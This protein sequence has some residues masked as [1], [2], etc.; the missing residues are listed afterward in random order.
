MF[1][2]EAIEKLS[3]PSQLDQLVKVVSLPY[4]VWVLG[5]AVIIGSAGAW[6]VLGSVS[7][8]VSGTALLHIRTGRVFPVAAAQQGL[9]DKLE[10]SAGDAVRKG[11][12]IARVRSLELRDQLQAAKA[13]L[14]A[15]QSRLKDIQEAHKRERAA[16]LKVRKQQYDALNTKIANAEKQR[17][18]IEGHL[19]ELNKLS[20]RGET[21][22]SSVDQMQDSLYKAIQDRGDAQASKANVEATF[23]SG[24]S[25]RAQERR[26]AKFEILKQQLTIGRLETDL[27]EAE[28]LLAPVDGSIT[29]VLVAEG[30]RITP[31]TVIMRV[32]E[33][34]DK[35]TALGFFRNKDGKRLE[36]GM[37]VNVSPSDVEAEE[38]GTIVGK[39]VRVAPRPQSQQALEALLQ[40]SS[41][42][43]H[44]TASGAPILVVIQ[45]AADASAPSGYKWSSGKGPPFKITD[46]TMGSARVIVEEQAPISLLVPFL[47]KLIGDTGG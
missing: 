23:L 5:L 25:E 4:W 38:Y 32:S 2:K 24:E 46:G 28:T 47:K 45:L 26:N 20:R 36:P 11:Q 1:R 22:R 27:K 35:L 39:L 16:A 33:R 19:E 44:L 10:V 14:T 41:V 7:T 30:A 8:R 42:A 18:R 43:Q 34:T 3:A 21:L 17:K 31:T 37:Q 6:S 13:T 12:V 9:V 29:E 15:L 40:N